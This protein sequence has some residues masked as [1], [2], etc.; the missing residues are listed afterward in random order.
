MARFKFM[1][2]RGVNHLKDCFPP[3]RVVTTETLGLRPTLPDEEIIE[4]ASENGHL[5]VASNRRDF[6][7]G[8][9][10]PCACRGSLFQ[11]ETLPAPLLVGIRFA[12]L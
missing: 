9:L 7:H 10:P 8:E 4:Y 3:K 1:L 12:H 5:L 2:D 6:L 11:T